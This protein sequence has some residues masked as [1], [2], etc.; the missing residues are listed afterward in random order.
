VG[1]DT[2]KDTDNIEWIIEQKRYQR[3]LQNRGAKICQA[4]G[5]RP[6]KTGDEL[7]VLK[8][9]IFEVLDNTGTMWRLRNYQDNVGSVPSSFL[10][11]PDRI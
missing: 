6:M 8:G 11:E 1:R 2:L 4:K 10:G 7:D 9:E 3:K 5:D